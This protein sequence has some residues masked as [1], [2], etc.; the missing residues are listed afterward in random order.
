MFGRF[1]YDSYLGGTILTATQ[2]NAWV[3][4]FIY[5]PVRGNNPNYRLWLPEV[6]KKVNKSDKLYVPV[7]EIKTI[8]DIDRLETLTKVKAMVG[9]NQAVISQI[10][11]MINRVPRKAIKLIEW[12]RERSEEQKLRNSGSV[13]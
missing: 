5:Q 3:A 11:D 2:V 6:A 12:K 10:D 7:E 8:V 4:L 1:L 13:Q 9:D